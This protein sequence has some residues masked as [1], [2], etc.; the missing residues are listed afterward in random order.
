MQ[1]MLIV[2]QPY[3]NIEDNDDMLAAGLLI[4]TS[5][6]FMDLLVEAANSNYLIDIER[7]E[8]MKTDRI[9]QTR[10]NDPFE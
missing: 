8:V 4:K 9:W 1:F 5:A 3:V 6:S 7:N 2:Q 10:E